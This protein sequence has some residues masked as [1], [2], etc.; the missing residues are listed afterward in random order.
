MVSEGDF[1][2]GRAADHDFELCARCRAREKAAVDWISAHTRGWH[3][4]S[5][6]F[7]IRAASLPAP[8]PVAEARRKDTGMG[9]VILEP[10]AIRS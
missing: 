7:G 6:A 4:N 5:Q 10:G 9:R 2:C 1:D 3:L 8:R